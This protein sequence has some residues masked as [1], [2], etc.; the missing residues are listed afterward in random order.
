MVQTDFL[1]HLLFAGIAPT[2]YPMDPKKSNRALGFPTLI[3]GLCQFYGVHIAPSK[4]IWTPIKKAFIEKYCTP[5]QAQGQAPQQP[6]EDQQP[7]V[8][9][10]PPPQ[11]EVPSLRSIFDRL[12]RIELH[13]HRYMHHVTSQQVTNHRRQRQLNETFYHYNMHQQSQ[14]P[15][16][17]PWP[18]PEQFEATVAWPRDE[19]D[20]ETH[21]GPRG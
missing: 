5:R 15:S 7:A 21:V 20:F 8:D 12:Q 6:K 14:D 4:V 11:E 9:T 16:P 13:M 19:I 3:T 10:P 18:T 17:F 2:R 1:C